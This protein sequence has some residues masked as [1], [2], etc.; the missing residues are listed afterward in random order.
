VTSRNGKDKKRNFR[1]SCVATRAAAKKWNAAF[2]IPTES[3]HHCDVKLF[4]VSAIYTAMRFW[5]FSGV[6]VNSKPCQNSAVK[7]SFRP[8]NRGPEFE[9][10]HG[11]NVVILKIFCGTIGV[12]D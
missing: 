9:I 3:S 2:S 4:Y 11:V 12:F 6:Y 7:W 8:P 10:D 5:L 1:C